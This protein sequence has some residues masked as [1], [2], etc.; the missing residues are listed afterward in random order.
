MSVTTTPE[1]L[2]AWE[3]WDRDHD[4][5]AQ[6]EADAETDFND[7]DAEVRGYD[8]VIAEK[9]AELAKLQKQRNRW[10]VERETAKTALTGVRKVKAAHSKTEPEQD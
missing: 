5:L 4:K 7:A 10:V 6:L 1:T 3:V 9:Q 8:E 2:T